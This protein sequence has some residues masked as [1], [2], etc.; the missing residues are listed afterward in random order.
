MKCRECEKFISCKCN[1]CGSSNVEMT[2]W[3]EAFLLWTTMIG[4]GLFVGVVQGIYYL[5]IK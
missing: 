4:M 5:I 3:K 2:H 1:H